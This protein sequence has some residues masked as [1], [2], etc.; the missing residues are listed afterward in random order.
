MWRCS[1]C[2][3]VQKE[4]VLIFSAVLFRAHLVS[5]VQSEATT[6]VKVNQDVNLFVTEV[7][8][9]AQVQFEVKEGRQAYMLCVEG[10]G[11]FVATDS[12]GSSSSSTNGSISSLSQHD[13]AELY[14]PLSFTA[15]P[16]GSEKLHV[17]VL[18]M[19]YTGTGRSDV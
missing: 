12:S 8:P 6:A 1:A 10:S 13:A 15:A 18:E 19:E 16:S 7:A 5:D 4:K 11:D 17:L 9:G 3:L 14:G 2:Q